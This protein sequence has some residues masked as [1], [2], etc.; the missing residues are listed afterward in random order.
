MKTFIGQD[1]FEVNSYFFSAPEGNILFDAPAG[2]DK[3]FAKEKID[4]LL[5]THGH[6]DHTTD[7][8]A[9]VRRHGCKVAIHADTVPMISDAEFFARW[10]L[11]YHIDPVEKSHLLLLTEGTH[12]LCG[13]KLQIFD[14]PGHCPGSICTLLTSHGALITGDVLFA[15]SIG[16][17]DLPGGD[18]NTLLSNIRTKL[19]T[20]PPLTRVLPGHGPASTIAQEANT[21]PFLT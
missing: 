18:M 16:R 12:I 4:L 14:T 6:F 13:E 17:T 11:P 8:A 21:N 9:I 5:L 1:D 19:L 3:H 10:G 2:A 20:L 15:S 7:A